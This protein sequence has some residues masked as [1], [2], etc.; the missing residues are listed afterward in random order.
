MPFKCSEC[1]DKSCA[2][3]G[4]TDAA[5]DEF[6]PVIHLQD[7]VETTHEP[8]P[9]SDVQVVVEGPDV[10]ATLAEHAMRLTVIEDLLAR[11]TREWTRG[12]E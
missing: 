5:C 1:A 11:V 12:R 7:V 10:N 2:N 3:Y 4:A 9:E 8:E 6:S